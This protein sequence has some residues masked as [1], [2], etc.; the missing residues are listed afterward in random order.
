MTSILF[1]T[2]CEKCSPYVNSLK[3]QCWLYATELMSM[4]QQIDELT[5]ENEFFKNA[6][7]RKCPG[8]YT[9]RE[10]SEEDCKNCGVPLKPVKLE[11]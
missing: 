7:M 1:R 10:K 5:K 11:E 2:E 6:T 3:R 9:F 8:C 4:Q